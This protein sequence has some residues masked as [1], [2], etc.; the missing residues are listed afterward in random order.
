M[1]IYIERY[2]GDCYQKS[3][4]I[5]QDDSLQPMYVFIRYDENRGLHLLI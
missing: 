1:V 5:N 4:I 3:A 2:K